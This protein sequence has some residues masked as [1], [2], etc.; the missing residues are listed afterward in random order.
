[1]TEPS[2]RSTKEFEIF[3][4]NL[5][6]RRQYRDEK[7]KAYVEA[8][9]KEKARILRVVAP[10]LLEDIE[11]EIREWFH[12]WYVGARTF[13]NYPPEEK[14][15]TILVVR[16]E[17][18]T[19]K[20]YL[21]DYERKRRAKVKAGGQDALKQKEAKEKKQKEEAERKKKEV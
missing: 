8:I 12:E 7:I 2:W 16:G 21:D 17:T 15:G 13:D 18:M 20:E 14:G 19:P 11:D 10:G 1:M 4:A 6:K 3:E 9:D 5:E